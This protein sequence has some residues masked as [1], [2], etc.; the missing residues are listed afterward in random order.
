MSSFEKKKK[1]ARVLRKMKLE[2]KLSI[3]SQ[4]QKYYLI[5]LY[6]TLKI[7]KCVTENRAVATKSLGKGETWGLNVHSISVR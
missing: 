6:E 4:I 5:P 2:G 7:F 1:Q 3:T